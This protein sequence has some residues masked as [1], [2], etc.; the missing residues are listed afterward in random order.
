VLSRHPEAIAFPVE[1]ALAAEVAQF[2]DI[3]L[4]IPLISLNNDWFERASPR[5]I[6]A[7]KQLCTALAAV[8]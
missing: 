6:L 4:K 1:A 7:A 8:K 5:I 2:W 3:Q